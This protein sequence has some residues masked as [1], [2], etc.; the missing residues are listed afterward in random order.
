[1]NLPTKTPLSKTKNRN[2]CAATLTANLY[3]RISIPLGRLITRFSTGSQFFF[4]PF[5]CVVVSLG[6]LILAWDGD[7]QPYES[8][9]DRKLFFFSSFPFSMPQ[10]WQAFF[11][12]RE[13]RWL[14]FFQF[15][16]VFY[17]ILTIFFNIPKNQSNGIQLVK[18]YNVSFF[19]VIHVTFQIGNYP[20]C[21]HLLNCRNSLSLSFCYYIQLVFNPR[22]AQDHFMNQKTINLI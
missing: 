13:K 3:L 14:G 8:S 21:Q 16:H 12:E 22:N 17:F 19:K 9:L 2:I 4:L 5:L 6:C 1:M 18:Q 11:L 15:Q 7:G 20:I 10:Y